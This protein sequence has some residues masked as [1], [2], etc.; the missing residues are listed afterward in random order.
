MTVVIYHRLGICRTRV[1]TIPTL[2]ARIYFRFMTS[3]IILLYQLRRRRRD[4]ASF[5]CSGTLRDAQQIDELICFLLHIH[6]ALQECQD[7]KRISSSPAQ[8]GPGTQLC[9]CPAL[10]SNAAYRWY[11]A[12]IHLPLDRWRRCIRQYQLDR[13][14]E[15]HACGASSWRS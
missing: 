7:A 11:I 6:S 2:L 3:T 9:H 5:P 12:S 4:V 10:S 14:R 8:S 15:S 13:C 1:F